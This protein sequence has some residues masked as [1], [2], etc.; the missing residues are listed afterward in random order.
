VSV[1]I[2]AE[3]STVVITERDASVETG[4]EVVTEVTVSNEAVE[5]VEVARSSYSPVLSTQTGTSYSLQA[6]DNGKIIRFTNA[7]DITVTCPNSLPAGFSVGIV[8]R[9]NGNVIFSA[10]SG[11][12]VANAHGYT[13]TFA[14]NAVASLIVDENSNGTSAHYVAGGDMM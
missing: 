12:T 11:A 13:R 4:D 10:A 6:T 1:N 8:Q 7:S 2:T 3:I 14:I 5:V 9:G